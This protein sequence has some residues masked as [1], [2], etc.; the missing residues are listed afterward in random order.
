MI[1]KTVSTIKDILKGT[2][3]SNRLIF[4]KKVAIMRVNVE[5]KTSTKIENRLCIHYF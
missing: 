5:I 4:M 1:N 2:S 3:I